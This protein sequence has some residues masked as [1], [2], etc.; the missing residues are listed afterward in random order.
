MWDIFFLIKSVEEIT[1]VK[2]IKNLIKN[3]KKPIDESNLKTIILEGFVP[4]SSE[5]F[6]YIKKKWENKYI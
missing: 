1:S 4:S 3:Y 6:D 2:E 5:M